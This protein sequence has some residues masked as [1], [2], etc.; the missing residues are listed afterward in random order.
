MNLN[1]FMQKGIAN[2]MKTAGRFYLNSRKGRAF[3]ARIIPEITRS[4]ALREENEK[5]GCHVP[6][7]LI[8]SIASRCNLSCAGCYARAG[9]ALKDTAC[10]G[11][12]SPADLSAEEWMA[13][14]AEAA[15]LG[16]AFI[17]LAG[18]EPLMRRD[19]ITAAASMPSLVFPV[20]TN[21]T[22]MDGEFL[23]LFDENRHL[24]PVLSLEGNREATD[25]RRGTGVYAGVESA[26]AELKE[27]RILFGVSVTVTRENMAEVLAESYTAELRSRGCGIVFFV[28][29]VPAEPGTE[30]LALDKAGQ[31]ELQRRTQGL[32]G[33]FSDTVI[34]SFSGDE[35][36]M[37]G[38]LASGRGFF[39]INPKGGAEPCPFS[40]FAKENIK[41]A[42]LRDILGS[43]YFGEIRN[44]AAGNHT[45]GCVLF[46]KEAEVR[47]ILAG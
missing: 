4:A 19:V 21:G 18:G 44:L 17:L 3:L 35:E 11:G 32:K 15:N 26:M 37:G 12:L 23:S 34:L 5:A 24:I 7:F 27:R 39:H 29:Y 47:A 16:T 42:S 1:I 31:E 9:G 30:S 13:V 40:P 41:N 46:E 20:F 36:A 43:R 22:L 14:F 33:R 38:C 8:A 45:G 25:V 10:G 28:E 6:P 2:I